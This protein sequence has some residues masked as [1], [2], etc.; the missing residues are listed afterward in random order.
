MGSQDTL[1]IAHSKWGFF[2]TTFNGVLSQDQPPTT[3]NFSAW[4]IFTSVVRPR[5]LSLLMCLTIFTWMPWN[6]RLL[7][8]AF[9]KAEKVHK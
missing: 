2:I 4:S 8:G 6:A 9:P 1:V 7:V 3:S 5:L